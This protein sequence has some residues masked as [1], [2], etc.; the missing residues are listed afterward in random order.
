MATPYILIVKLSFY[1]GEN[2]GLSS[3]LCGI[4]VAFNSGM[5]KLRNGQTVFQSVLYF[6]CSQVTDE[7]SSCFN[8]LSV[9]VIIRFY[10]QGGEGGM[11]NCFHFNVFFTLVK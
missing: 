9:F 7:C 8:V 10:W 2:Y 5:I 4:A 6:A 1:T 11:E 3:C